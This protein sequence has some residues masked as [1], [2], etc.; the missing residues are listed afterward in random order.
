MDIEEKA[1]AYHH[2]DRIKRQLSN[3]H[4]S[5]RAEI[6]ETLDKLIEQIKEL[7]H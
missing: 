7:E 3:L 6:L 1:M 4:Y 5:K 2:V